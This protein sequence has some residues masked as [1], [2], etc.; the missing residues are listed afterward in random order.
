MFGWV[1]NLRL[2]AAV[3]ADDLASYK[4]ALRS[5]ANPLHDA[6]DHLVWDM[7]DHQ[8]R[9]S[10]VKEAFAWAGKQPEGSTLRDALGRT[11]IEGLMKAVR[12]AEFAQTLHNSVAAKP[13]PTLAQQ[14]S[15]SEW[16]Y[17]LRVAV[18][19]DLRSPGERAGDVATLLVQLKT[20][21]TTEIAEALK[22][23][24]HRSVKAGA[25]GNALQ[26]TDAI[27]SLRLAAARRDVAT[28]LSSAFLDKYPNGRSIFIDA[29]AEPHLFNYLN[30]TLGCY[31]LSP[32]EALAVSSVWACNRQMFSMIHVG[33]TRRAFAAL[34]GQHP[35]A[36]FQ[37]LA[38]AIA[39]DNLSF[40]NTANLS[41]LHD[42]GR[43]EL[44]YNMAARTPR[45]EPQQGLEKTVAAKLMPDNISQ[46]TLARLDLACRD[47]QQRGSAHLSGLRQAIRERGSQLR[48]PAYTV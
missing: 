26:L 2:V 22:Y 4:K 1:K 44:L 19:K 13:G 24:L 28:P 3:K 32:K 12:P 35:V 42:N 40:V 10:F 39:A 43:I 6:A 5:G 29:A 25:T 18:D 37:Q 30:D 9:A 48:T 11:L 46:A 23:T 36:S 27:R 8:G 45:L 15:P 38:K 21:I 17:T 20:P 47:Y 41:R 7:V 31:H 34:Q 16:A 33:E 14:M